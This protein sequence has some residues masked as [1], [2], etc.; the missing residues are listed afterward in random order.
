MA[1]TELKNIERKVGVIGDNRCGCGATHITGTDLFVGDWVAFNS[2]DSSGADVVLDFKV[3][4]YGDATVVDWE[5]F[6]ADVSISGRFNQQSLIYGNFTQIRLV[7]GGP[8]LAYKR[9]K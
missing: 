3:A 5:G 4:A 6:E 7:S 1:Q 9:C 8:I 2:I